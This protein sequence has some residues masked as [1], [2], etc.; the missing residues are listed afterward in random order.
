MQVKKT[1]KFEVVNCFNKMKGEFN[2]IDHM[3]LE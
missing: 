2:A 3:H 1:G